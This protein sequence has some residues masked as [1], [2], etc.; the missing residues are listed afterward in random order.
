MVDYSAVVLDNKSK[1]MLLKKFE[2]IIPENYEIIAHHMTINLGELEPEFK[3]F[4]NLP[5]RL[6]VNDF[7]YDDKAIAVGVSGF[8]SKNAK[9][10]ITLA[11]NRQNGGKPQM[12]NN[13]TNW[14]KL[15][16]PIYV[17]GKITEIEY[18]L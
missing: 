12:S 9:P 14:T 8:Y 16:R 15:K 5:V 11:V 17:T 7:A 13:L 1:Q 10:H 6:T 3:K 2:S 18:N 4:L